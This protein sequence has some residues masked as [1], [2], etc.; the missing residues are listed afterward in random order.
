[1]VKNLPVTR[2]TWV[3][4]LDEED[5]L[6]EKWQPTPVFLL[7]KPHGQRSWAGYNRVAKSQTPLSD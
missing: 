3:L 1:M 6:E 4:S 5:P 2:E 7:G